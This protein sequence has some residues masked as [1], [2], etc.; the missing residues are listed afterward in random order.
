MPKDYDF[1]VRSSYKEIGRRYS[2]FLQDLMACAVSDNAHA[3]ADICEHR[4]AVKILIDD[5]KIVT[6]FGKSVNQ[7]V[8]DF[9]GAYNDDL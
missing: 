3:V 7:S 9:A 6:F 5:D 2:C 4:K 8:T 1:P